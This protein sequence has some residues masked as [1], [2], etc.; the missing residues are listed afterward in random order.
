MLKNVEINVRGGILAPYVSFVILQ[1]V[2]VGFLLIGTPLLAHLNASNVDETLS[3]LYLSIA[4]VRTVG[5][6]GTLYALIAA[7]AAL[8]WYALGRS[9]D[10]LWLSERKK[11]KKKKKKRAD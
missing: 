4:Y 7:G 2:A 5:G 1:I 3:V 10:A 6:T 9:T 8:L 11:A